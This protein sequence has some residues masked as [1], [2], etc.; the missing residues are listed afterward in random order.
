MSSKYHQR[1][2]I[3]KCAIQQQTLN[4]DTKARTN[5]LQD[6]SEQLSDFEYS[7][8][9]IDGGNTFKYKIE[10]VLTD[11]RFFDSIRAI[12]ES[13][14]SSKNDNVPT[15]NVVLPHFPKLL[16]QWGYDSKYEK[17]LLSSIHVAQISDISYKF[18]DNKEKIVQI[19][20]VDLPTFA[21]R[22]FSTDE[23]KIPVFDKI[24]ITVP[25]D[26]ESRENGEDPLILFQEIE[27][28]RLPLSAYSI[29]KR[30]IE[31]VS[32]MIK[33]VVYLPPELGTI[34]REIDTEYKNAIN[35]YADEI[36]KDFAKAEEWYPDTP[37]TNVGIKEFVSKQLDPYKHELVRRF[38]LLAQVIKKLFKVY[39]NLDVSINS[40]KSRYSKNIYY[41]SHWTKEH[42]GV[43][44]HL[45]LGPDNLTE[46]EARIDYGLVNGTAPQITDYRLRVGNADDLFLVKGAGGISTAGQE[47]FLNNYIKDAAD[48]NKLYEQ[49]NV[50]HR[51]AGG[52]DVDWSEFSDQ[53]EF[54]DFESELIEFTEEF[55]NVQ[56]SG[57][58]RA[59]EFY[60]NWIAQ[61]KKD[62]IKHAPALASFRIF[63]KD[64]PSVP[65]FLRGKFYPIIPNFGNTRI[66]LPVEDSATVVHDVS[67]TGTDEYFAF[68][69][70]LE[71]FTVKTLIDDIIKGEMLINQ[72]V[73]S[74]IRAQQ[75]ERLDI[76]TDPKCKEFSELEVEDRMEIRYGNMEASLLVPEGV[77]LFNTLKSIIDKHN[78]LFS[79]PKH[80]IHF[81]T[82]NFNDFKSNDMAEVVSDLE[83]STKEVTPYVLTFGTEDDDTIHPSRMRDIK[84]FSLQD[85]EVQALSLESAPDSKDTFELQ[86]WTR[87]NKHKPIVFQYGS[88]DIDDIDDIVNFFE[89]NGDLRVLANMSLGAKSIDEITTLSETLNPEDIQNE[90]VPI[91]KDIIEDE[92]GEVKDFFMMR[93][94]NDSTTPAQMEEKYNDLITSL[95]NLYD[96]L[97]TEKTSE[98]VTLDDSFFDNLSKVQDNMTTFSEHST[99][100]VDYPY[101]ARV[102]YLLANRAYFNQMFDRTTDFGDKNI[103][104]I[105][106][107]L[108]VD[109]SG[110][111]VPSPPVLKYRFK[112]DNI[113][114]IKGDKLNLLNRIGAE[115]FHNSNTPWEV[116]VKTLGIPELDTVNDIFGKRIVELRVKD[117][118]REY[119]LMRN[120]THWLTGDYQII[121]LKHNLNTKGYTSEFTLLKML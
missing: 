73:D 42:L 36:S 4:V 8:L 23:V 121:G 31:S 90:F 9:N 44:G 1:T 39:F 87:A 119:Q 22:F 107:D 92:T 26:A 30:L 16:I 12:Y 57:R 63:I 97:T 3:F 64:D 99:K 68:N 41:E 116:K 115:Y 85:K 37:G 93:I 71:S 98:G 106:T 10:F 13:C 89:F 40:K 51:P 104:E 52:D 19:Q 108:S 69:T 20:A 34:A 118:S 83:G 79:N 113:F 2:P 80:H 43:H 55:R 21:D 6:L 11:D 95:Q 53:I 65:E 66:L 28:K 103:S 56:K 45:F 25:G 72:N 38:S 48:N 32:E 111:L 112:Q 33:G 91:L 17:D 18:K 35:R 110:Q 76:V 84:S 49:I 74:S 102:L 101:F 120:A 14:Y 81:R 27:G 24:G 109:T 70:S 77:N 58:L 88:Q 46:P 82:F 15:G 50:F 5:T 114:N 61:E 96:A 47:K 86:K 54:L 59:R 7:V 75:I 29:L 62:F 78:S 60:F 94:G 105:E 117:L 67:E 100:D